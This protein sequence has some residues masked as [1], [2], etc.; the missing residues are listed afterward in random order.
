MSDR[1]YAW[2]PGADLFGR[3][4]L[5]TAT[6]ALFSYFTFGSRVLWPGQGGFECLILGTVTAA[7]LTL[8]GRSRLLEAGL[9]LGLVDEDEDEGADGSG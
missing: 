6:A 7:M 5:G 4:W 9:G 3:F 8:V 2:S 1:S